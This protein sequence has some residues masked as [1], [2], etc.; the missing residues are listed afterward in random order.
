[1][2]IL[3]TRE[4]F[5]FATS[6]VQEVGRPV[7]FKQDRGQARRLFITMSD[8]EVQRSAKKKMRKMV[9]QG[10]NWERNIAYL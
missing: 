8:P 4:Y 10:P 1:L 9:A 5:L 2:V 7:I 3:R 6:Y